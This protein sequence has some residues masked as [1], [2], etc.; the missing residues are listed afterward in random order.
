MAE[1][2]MLSDEILLG[3]IKKN[4]GGG[5]GTTDY[6]DLSNKPQINGNTLSGNKSLADLGIA[7]A[8]EVVKDV[9]VDGQSCVDANRNAIVQITIPTEY[10]YTVSKVDNLTLKV[11]TKQN[12]AV[13]DETNYTLSGWSAPVNIDN[14]I[15]LNYSTSGGTWTVETLAASTDY[16]AGQ[17]WTWVYNQTPSVPVLTFEEA[18]NHIGL[19]AAYADLKANKQDTLT[20]DDVPTANSN[21]PV[22]SGGVKSAIDAAVA[23]AYHHAGTKTCAE[24]VAGLLVAANE[25]NVYNMTDSGTTTADFIEGAGQPIK[26]GDNVGVAKISDGVYKFD[27]LSGFVDTTNFVQ[28]SQTAGLLKNDGTV[29]DEIE[30]D[31]STLKSG[32]TDLTDHVDGD[33]TTYPYA[34]VITVSDAV[35]AN[36]AD[37]SVKVEPVQ[38]LHGYDKPWVGGAN[39]NKYDDSTKVQNQMLLSG[40]NSY[41]NSW[42]DMSDYI[43]VTGNDGY[44]T[45]SWDSTTS[46]YQAQ[47]CAY[48]SSKQFISGSYINYENNNARTHAFVVPNNA[49]YVRFSWAKQ[50]SGGSI[51]QTNIRVNLGNADLGY[52]PYSNICPISGHTEAVVQRD[53]RNL[54]PG[55][56]QYA[57]SNI[58]D[59]GK[60][61]NGNQPNYDLYGVYLKDGNYAISMTETYE[62]GSTVRVMAFSNTS[63]VQSDSTLLLKKSINSAGASSGTFTVDGKNFLLI[64]LRKSIENTQLE[65]GSTATTYE[66]YA[67]QQ[68]TLALGD[69]IY[70]GTVDFDSGVMTVVGA[71]YKMLSADV[72]NASGSFAGRY[73]TGSNFVA[74]VETAQ[75]ILMCDAFN[76]IHTGS[77]TTVGDCYVT[78]NGNISF[79]TSF[80]SLSDFQTYL[81][82]NDVYVIIP[83]STPTTIQLTPEQI[84]LLQGT[85]T[86]YASTGQISVTVNGVS[87]AIGSVQEQVNELAEDKTGFVKIAQPIKTLTDST[88]SYT[89]PCDCYMNAFL[90]SS[91]GYTAYIKVGNTEIIS[92]SNSTDPDGRYITLPL[93]KGSVI[94]MREGQDYS[95]RILFYEIA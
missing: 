67:G 18:E 95:Y 69:T 12:G 90:K 25:G 87:G 30:G 9:K 94:T 48:D 84:Q 47:L 63:Y 14:H 74:D 77:S 66:P 16:P 45:L 44:V 20:F 83:V 55:V 56:V 8:S 1:D 43:D 92:V 59:D 52:A 11:T 79:N 64:Q 91:T 85:N 31:V 68:Y 93:K 37:C 38:D 6:D 81:D 13:T 42:F 89:V 5:G 70:G 78:S 15:Q 57:D 86:L 80:E 24:L 40:G 26:A 19:S 51:G 61:N 23:S 88:E 49:K 7:G 46:W 72:T 71:K 60:I 36:L 22:K 35:P 39:T 17:T 33:A 32:L 50:Y 34:D 53:G 73:F 65:L 28:K 27:L 41:E 82:N 29:N 62:S 58:T 75:R 4:S 3:L 2:R 54:F 76:A 10:E 21:N